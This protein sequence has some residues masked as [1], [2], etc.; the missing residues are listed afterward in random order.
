VDCEV[1]R[2]PATN[3]SH[4]GNIT[5]QRYSRPRMDRRSLADRLLRAGK[6]TWIAEIME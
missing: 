6:R 1:I 3:M 5:A 2:L 4:N